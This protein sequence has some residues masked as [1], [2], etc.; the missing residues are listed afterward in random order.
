LRNIIKSSSKRELIPYVTETVEKYNTYGFNLY[1]KYLLKVTDNIKFNF[2]L[3]P[4][5]TYGSKV[6]KDPI[7]LTSDYSLIMLS[8]FVGYFDYYKVTVRDSNQKA[9]FYGFE[10]D[11]SFSYQINENIDL[12][13]GGNLI[14]NKIRYQNNGSLTFAVNPSTLRY[15]NN[16]FFYGQGIQNRNLYPK[17]YNSEFLYSYYLGVNLKF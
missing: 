14:Y 5:Y 4:F 16:S 6:N 3:Q 10:L 15:D 13:F 2:F 12:S 1:F 9:Y 11:L 7:Y 8:G 17:I